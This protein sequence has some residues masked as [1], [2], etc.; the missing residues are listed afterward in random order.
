MEAAQKTFISSTFW[1]ERIGPA[2]A[3]AT[4]K[5]MERLHSWD[6]ITE[7]GN[8]IKRRWQMLAD[9]YELEISQWGIPA[10]AGFTFKSENALAYKTYITQEMLS[11]GYLAG[12]SVYTCIEHTPEILDGYFCELDKL[13][14]KIK[15]FEQGRDVMRELK[16]PICHSGF[17]RLN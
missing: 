10:L 1:T 3:I 8:N 14:E 6:I 17:K 4:L 15:E 16:G 11:K 12:N 5:V 7:A 2:A 13:F 9:K